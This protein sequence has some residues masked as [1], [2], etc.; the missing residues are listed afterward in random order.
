MNRT[1][2]IGGL[3]EGDVD[4]IQQ[5]VRLELYGNQDIPND[6]L[7]PL[8]IDVEEKTDDLAVKIE[9]GS[10]FD[11][12]SAH[13]SKSE[14][15][16]S[17]RKTSTCVKLL[18]GELFDQDP[19]SLASCSADQIYKPASVQE[20]QDDGADK[21]W[22]KKMRRVLETLQNGDNAAL[23]GP[24][25]SGK[26]VTASRV[27]TNLVDFGWGVTR[28]DYSDPDANIVDLLRSLLRAPQPNSGKQLIIVDNVQSNPRS[29]EILAQILRKLCTVL[30][31]G[32][33]NLFIGW[34]TT[35]E[36]ITGEFPNITIHQLNPTDAIRPIVNEVFDT[37]PS[38]EVIDEIQDIARGDLFVT[39]LV[40]DYFA[41]HGDTPRRQDIAKRRFDETTRGV[42]L[43][44]NQLELLYR[45]AAIGQFEI[46]IRDTYA[47][48]R[49]GDAVDAFL[50]A[51]VL[52]RSGDF[53][54]LGHRT[55][56]RL[57]VEHIFRNHSAV[58][59]DVGE[60]V[61]LAANYLRTAGGQQIRTALERLDLARLQFTDNENQTSF[62]ARS[63]QS[64][65]L[66]MNHLSQQV[67][68][69]PTWD[70]NTASAIFTA[71]AFARLSDNKWT[72]PAEFV[73]NRWKVG[74]SDSLPEPTEEVTSERID[75]DKIQ[76]R[77]Q[78]EDENR[79]D[80]EIRYPADEINP[81]RA[82]RTWVLG[83]LLGFEAVALDKEPERLS[84]LKDIA[85]SSINP[86]GWFYPARVPWITAR[87]VLGLTEAGESYYTSEAVRRACDWL[88]QPRPQGGAYDPNIG[89]W[90]S[91]TGSWN[92]DVM[93]T[94]M[95]VN[96]LMD[97][98][99]PPDKPTIESGI[100]YV[101]DNREIWTADG[102]EIDAILVIEA[103]QNY[104]I[105]WHEMFTEVNRL[106]EWV[107][108]TD[109]WIKAKTTDEDIEDESSKI[110]F[111]S[112]FLI[113]FIWNQM[114][115]ELPRLLEGINAGVEPEEI[116]SPAI[117][118]NDRNIN[119]LERE[120]NDIE[121]R[122]QKH[123]QERRSA[124]EDGERP[125]IEKKLDKWK[126]RRHKL[127]KVEKELSDGSVPL[128][129]VAE[130][131]D[132]LGRKC[133]PDWDP[134]LERLDMETD[135]K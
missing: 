92:T 113:T 25:A 19:S 10:K 103:L 125:N 50:D 56:C 49:H 116:T 63:W 77:M 110:P 39:E 132:D 117:P 15:Q 52:R 98:G 43:T 24:S 84:K 75:F 58:V 130:R 102:N 86:A 62:L 48:A 1:S 60:P 67:S 69:D 23:I 55:E 35:K 127:Q 100:Q 89:A 44:T 115:E 8:E 81:C 121:K 129:K 120:L 2:L 64:L 70:E 51:G 78:E 105:K 96:A 99:L 71:I 12:F 74:D 13:V 124:I 133:I 68:E 91:G 107:Q 7:L 85:E 66:L 5:L 65:Q 123:I 108:G 97:A 47:K 54:S 34:P 106:L 114:Q 21:A 28:I 17:V 46:H 37:K 111:I 40:A 38:N 80:E 18:F 41:E 11:S 33:A 4:A 126:G 76:E 57:I 14:L 3:Y 109:E 22:T 88:R 26:T 9:L 53:L 131:I 6:P 59:S 83:L 27:A 30:D 104:G 31:D 90:P 94:A 42:D 45:V 93:T 135:I 134:V 20:I 72:E 82:H 61:D 87:V 73:R 95:C 36:T 122:I 112:N 16:A 119:L 118:R 79:P 29:F 128:T 101:R 32:L